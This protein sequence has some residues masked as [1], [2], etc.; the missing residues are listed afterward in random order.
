MMKKIFTAIILA[1]LI[2][3]SAFNSIYANTRE[4]TNSAQS[5]MNAG[6][7]TAALKLLE[8]AR[9]RYPQDHQAFQL[10][11]IILFKIGNT[12][13]A[14]SFFKQANKLYSGDYVSE[15]Y[16]GLIEL[17][18]KNTKKASAL[19]NSALAKNP[20]YPL[21]YA[22]LGEAELLNGHP[23]IARMNIKK[24]LTQTLD[25][26]TTTVQISANIYKKYNMTN[27]VIYTY[28]YYIDNNSEVT[29]PR[30]LAKIHFLLAQT[31]E[32]LK[33]KQAEK[34]FRE[35]VSLHPKNAFY[36]ESLA[37]YLFKTG[38][39]PEAK[40]A[41]DNALLLGK[42]SP[43]SYYSAALIYFQSGNIQKAKALFE[44]AIKQNPTHEKSHEGLSA[45]ALRNK[46]YSKSIIHNNIILKANP[47]NDTAL[48]NNACAYAMLGKTKEALINLSKA[49]DVNKNNKKFA[50]TEKMFDKIRNSSDFK[51]L[52][53][54]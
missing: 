36:R 31:Y 39:I 20:E 27:D 12:A 7:N 54:Q 1:I 21:P 10:T 40:K 2:F 35:A 15:T 30:D 26:D 29:N 9:T 28:K 33:N 52:L 13:K 6:N 32:K 19:F 46:E 5:M 23:N 53:H 44:K 50:E 37:N 49:I 34:S 45:I 43:S 48:Y 22:G 3:S 51:K 14:E 42:L 41:F 38:N 17:R 18:R 47:R 16:L 24:A 8:K 25:G 4:L 11:G